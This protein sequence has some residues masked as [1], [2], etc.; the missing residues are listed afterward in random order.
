MKKMNYKEWE[1]KALVNN[2]VN[3]YLV[4]LMEVGNTQ[5]KVGC[6][7]FK[8]GLI[9]CFD[10]SAWFDELELGKYCVETLEEN[11]P[12]F[13]EFNT[14]LNCGG[15]GYTEEINCSVYSGSD[16]CG[17]CY[18]EVLCNCEEHKPVQ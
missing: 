6:F 11:S 1:I 15:E 10:G 3:G 13:K 2:D 18:K 14:C 8:V 16:C 9:D 5:P 7:G 4:R 17:G 12:I